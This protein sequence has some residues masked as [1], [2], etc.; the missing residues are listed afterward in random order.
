ELYHQIGGLMPRDNNK[1]LTFAQIYFYN[2]NLDSQLQRRQEI[3]SSLNAE[4]LKVLQVELNIIN[5][6][7]NQ[8]VTS[9]IKAKNESDNS[10]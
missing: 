5:L 8:F 3:F 9:G 4:M 7:V 10:H 2:S 1:K 6:F